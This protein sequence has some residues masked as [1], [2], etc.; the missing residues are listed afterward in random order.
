GASLLLS[1]TP[2]WWGTWWFRLLAVLAVLAAA[3]GF[4]RYRLAQAL[5][6]SRMRDR[7]ARDLHDEI[8]ST[9]SSVAI[10]SEVAM[11]QEAGD[12]EGRHAVLSRI[13]QSTSQMME[14]M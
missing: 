11:R 13:S 8:G 6:L 2:P 3:Y 7:I 5:A 12:A 1:I 14:S 4:H 10:F 9:L